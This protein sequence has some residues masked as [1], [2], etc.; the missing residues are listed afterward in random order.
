MTAEDYCNAYGITP[1]LAPLMKKLNKADWYYLRR[2]TMDDGFV[3]IKTGFYSGSGK[4]CVRKSVAPQIL[5]AAEAV[6]FPA[7]KFFL[8][9]KNSAPNERV[10][11]TI[12]PTCVL[13]Q[14][15][16]DKFFR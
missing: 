12:I 6:N 9:A 15:E 7:F 14:Q 3:L 2:V 5:R 4:F 16:N 13:K 10:R 11:I 8:N 1:T